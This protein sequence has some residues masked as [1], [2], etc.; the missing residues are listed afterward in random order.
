MQQTQA[1]Q[2]PITFTLSVL[3]HYDACS[4]QYINVISP[5]LLPPGPLRERT[6]RLPSAYAPGR[7]RAYEGNGCC[8]LALLSFCGCPGGG[9]RGRG[10]ARTDWMTPFDVPDLLTFLTSNGYHINARITDMLNGSEVRASPGKLLFVVSYGG[11][12]GGSYG[13]GH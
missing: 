11:S 9:G 12:Y 3:P 7:A 8:R 1:T 13:S 6:R 4:Q 2:P 5:N 10:Q